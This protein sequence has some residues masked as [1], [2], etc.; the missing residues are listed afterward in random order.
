MKY[1]DIINAHSSYGSKKEDIVAICGY[2]NILENVVI[3]PWWE[4]TFF[5]K[6]GF[7]STQESSIVYNMKKD[8]IEF[9]FIELK[10]IGAPIVMEYVLSLG[11]T[12]CK[13]L[14]FIGS[15]GSLDE[16]IKIGDVVIPSYSICGDGATRYLNNNF[17][18]EFGKKEYP[19]HELNEKIINILEDMKVRYH[20]VPNF[21]VDS[22]F[23]EFIHIE[24]FLK[25][26][27]KTVEM[28]TANLFK[29]CNIMNIKTTA[30]FG[31][32]DNIVLRK[33]LYN[34]R[35]EEEKK[36]KD[37]CKKELI[38]QIVIEFFKRN[39]G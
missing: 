12:K 5:E 31:V 7:V 36:N 32:S 4:H 26:E 34:G 23:C 1:E 14:I 33:S 2:E 10:A 20:N 21:S 6:Y 22:V 18:D 19:S 9:S 16:T 17:E 30:I 8:D 11:V 13:N 3:A 25:Y 37:Y 28:E 35:S 38:P 29:C 24:D 15:C 27:S 39:K